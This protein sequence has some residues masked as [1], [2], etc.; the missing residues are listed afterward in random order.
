REKLAEFP[1]ATPAE[2]RAEQSHP[3]SAAA[4]AEV[5][6]PLPTTK[7]PMPALLSAAI[8]ISVGMPVGTAFATGTTKA[9]RVREFTIVLALGFAFFAGGA[10]LGHWF[11]G[12]QIDAPAPTWK[13]N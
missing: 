2:P 7:S 9:R 11:R 4:S 12:R 10:F 1:Q 13:A 6:P 5:P 8:P 3:H